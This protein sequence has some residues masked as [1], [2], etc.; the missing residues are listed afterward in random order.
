MSKPLSWQAVGHIA[1]YMGSVL[2]ANGYFTNLGQKVSKEPVQL[3]PDTDTLPITHVLM[4]GEITDG[5]TQFGHRVKQVPVVVESYMPAMQIDAHE[6][7]HE[8][9]D[10]MQRC[11]PKGKRLQTNLPKGMFGVEI[12]GAR[13]IIPAEIPYIVA[14]IELTVGVSEPTS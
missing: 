4:D 13:I 1:D 10:D 5:G 6:K 11:L 12:T 3:D 8:L 7:A 2:I 9:L 14:Q